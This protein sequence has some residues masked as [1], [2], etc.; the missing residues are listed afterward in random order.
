MNIEG[1]EMSASVDM[2]MTINN[3]GEEVVIETPTDLDAYEEV[4]E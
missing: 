1:M 4:E 3:P 2:D